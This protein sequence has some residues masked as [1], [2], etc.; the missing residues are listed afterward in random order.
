MPIGAQA[1]PLD[2]REI[3]A[4]LQARAWARIGVDEGALA[5]RFEQRRQAYRRLADAAPGYLDFDWGLD[6]SVTLDHGL[7]GSLEEMFS[8]TP[9]TPLQDPALQAWLQLVW[10][11]TAV[12][13]P[14]QSDYV[15][16]VILA[17]APTGDFNAMAVPLGDR[18]AIVVEEGLVRL[19]RRLCALVTPLLF[20]ERDG[21]ILVRTKQQV[22]AF[23][24]A[25]EGPCFDIAQLFIDYITQGE[26]DFPSPRLAGSS[27]VERYADTLFQ[28]FIAFVLWHEALHLEVGCGNPTAVNHESVE[29]DA[30]RM[31]AALAEACL[32]AGLTLDP[33]RLRQT[34]RHQREESDADAYAMIRVAVYGSRTNSLPGN[35]TGAGA[36]LLA[37][38]TV[39]RMLTQIVSPELFAREQ[40]SDL[41]QL[42]AAAFLGGR[43]HPHPRVRRAEVIGLISALD[44][45]VGAMVG[46]EI[47][48]L[49]LV[50]DRVWGL[51]AATIALE[52][53]RIGAAASRWLTPASADRERMIRAL[54]PLDGI[55][56]ITDAAD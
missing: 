43:D 54:A 3:V 33:E 1:A 4:R 23:V 32:R 53:D 56:W 18:G 38:D 48:R 6:P 41:A 9:A 11:Y 42:K 17:T 10:R 45:G 39:H 8:I 52:H 29:R 12:H 49:A 5:E 20:F 25:D 15:R 24:A 36:F 55:A 47:D 30:E 51:L 46:F 28:S 21:A 2:L 16:D 37:L 19:A 34:Y 27:L 44:P 35:V 7:V 50:F 14:F 13:L 40:A 22:E 26:V 31:A